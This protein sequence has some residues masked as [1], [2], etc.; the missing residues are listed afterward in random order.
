MKTLRRQRHQPAGKAGMLLCLKVASM[1]VAQ[2][3]RKG[4]WGSWQELSLGLIGFLSKSY[5]LRRPLAK[6]FSFSDSILTVGLSVLR[7]RYFT[8]DI[9]VG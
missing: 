3:P 2:K 7:S 8:L 9:M 5:F 1:S 6:S 4:P